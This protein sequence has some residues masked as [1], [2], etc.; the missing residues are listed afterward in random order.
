MRQDYLHVI[1]NFPC[2]STDVPH[3]SLSEGPP[4][5]ACLPSNKAM[6]FRKSRTL[7]T[8]EPLFLV[9]VYRLCDCSGGMSYGCHR[10]HSGSFPGQYMWDF[11]WTEWVLFSVSCQYHFINASQY[12]L[13]L[14]HSFQNFEKG[15]LTRKKKHNYLPP[16]HIIIAFCYKY[17]TF[18]CCPN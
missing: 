4:G 15:M 10:G 16:I 18:L 5:R 11:S 17:F 2:N 7:A 12:F 6:P 14:Y 8:E 9:Y 1:R 13:S 3:C